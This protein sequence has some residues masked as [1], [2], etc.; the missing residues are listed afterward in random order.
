MCS[1]DLAE[2]NIWEDDFLQDA[3]VWQLYFNRR[4][5]LI[6]ARSRVFYLRKQSPF[7][8]WSAHKKRLFSRP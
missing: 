5:E 4:W 3:Q 7:V 8:S 2:S 1:D 6:V